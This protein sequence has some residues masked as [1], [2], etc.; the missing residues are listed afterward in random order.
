[1]LLLIINVEAVEV[2][3]CH[4]RKR[5]ENLGDI[6]GNVS[7]CMDYCKFIILLLTQVDI[8]SFTN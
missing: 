4:G 3:K 1:M 5:K 7:I 2:A 8:P 6:L